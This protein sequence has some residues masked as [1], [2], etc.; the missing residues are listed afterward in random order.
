MKISR[1]GQYAVIAG[2][3]YRVTIMPDRLLALVRKGRRFYYGMRLISA[4]DAIEGLDLARRAPRLRPLRRKGRAVCLDIDVDSTIW[5]RKTHHFVFRDDRIEFYTVVQGTGKVD[6]AYYFRGILN[7]CD[8][9][10]V[11]GFTQI[12]S[13]QAN[14]IEKQEF[15]TG[16]FT[17]IAAGEDEVLHKTIRHFGLF[18]APLCYVFHEGDSGPFLCAGILAKP[19]QNLFH[20]LEVNHWPEERRSKIQWPVVG[21]QALSLA[22]HG[23]Q[24]VQGRWQT[25]TLLLQFAKGR[26]EAVEQYVREFKAFGG[27]IKRTRRYQPWTFKPVYCTWHDQCA[28]STCSDEG[29]DNAAQR[30]MPAADVLTQERCEHWLNLL[31]KEDLLPG[32]YIIDAKWQLNWGD[33]VVDTAKFPDLRGF[34]DRC[35][36]KGVKVILH[37]HLWSGEGLPPQECLGLNGK[38]IPMPD[39][40]HPRYR[41]RIAVMMRRMLSDA[42]GC[43]NADGLKLDSA[44]YPGGRT[45]KTYSG[46]AGFELARVHYELFS[47]EARKVKPDSVMGLF[48]ALPYLAD[49]CDFART[50]DLYSVRGCPIWANAFRARMINIVIPGVAVDTDG[51]LEFNA[52]LPDEEVLA[53]QVAS[54]VPCLYQIEKQAII[55]DFCIP[56]V[57]T[58]DAADYRRIRK[59]WKAYAKKRR[60]RRSMGPGKKH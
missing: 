42:R 50:G 31:E 54:G 23:H 49:L 17:S 55:R 4:I 57:K 28:I 1:E 30:H 38:K 9:G 8:L 14:F 47:R 2:P 20:A 13:P 39:P 3:Q 29:G 12:F 52:V 22:Y 43:Y 58:L 19:G 51:E 48:S 41:K 37:N 36:R 7:D 21:S 40:T 34:V 45:L 26:F 16:E 33:N 25:P 5:K 56:Q 44:T 59:H 10:S 27:M 32:S 6:R 60:M 24:R 53:G 35:H 15:H 11:G 46:L 18:G